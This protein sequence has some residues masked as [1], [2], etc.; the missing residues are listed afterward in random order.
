MD[1]FIWKYEK[2]FAKEKAYFQRHTA[3]TTCSPYSG[4]DYSRRAAGFPTGVENIEGAL[5]NLM[6]GGLKSIHGGSMNGI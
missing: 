3:L 6:G 1:H 2:I 4:V 5:Q